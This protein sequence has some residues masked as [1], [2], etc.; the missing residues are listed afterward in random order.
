[1]R[2]VK[3]LARAAA[4]LAAGHRLLS[5]DTRGQRLRVR[6]NLAAKRHERARAVLA[7]GVRRSPA[8]SD[9]VDWLLDNA[10][11]V[12]THTAD[13]RRNLPSAYY[14]FLPTVEEG[15]ET[16]LRVYTLARQLV[17]S[18][19]GRVTIESITRCLDAY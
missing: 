12:R 13:I 1:G 8:E 19:D 7:D 14:R 6:L 17:A 10:H 2:P 16:L 11:V 5:A 9:V 18:T 3:G 15:G 4:D